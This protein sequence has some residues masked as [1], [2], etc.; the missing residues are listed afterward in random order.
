MIKLG[1][2]GWG[3][4]GR[5]YIK[6]LDTTVDAELSWVCELRPEM[7]SDVKKRY[8]HVH[9]TASVD[10]LIKQKLDGIIIATPATTHFALAKKIIPT[11]TAL[12][13]EKP[14][15]SSLVQ[16]V[17]LKQLVKKYKACVLVGHTF[18]YNQAVRWLKAK[19]DKR[20]FGKLFHI[21]CKRQS[22]GPIR[23]DVNIIWDFAPHDLSMI[24]YLLG[25]KMPTSIFAKAKRYMRH[26][27]EDIASIMLE[28]GSSMLVTINVAWLYPM[29][30]RML[31][32]LGR[33]R[34]AVFEDTN[35]IEPVKIYNTIIRYPSE[36]DPYKAA[37]RLGNVFIP[38][39]E[40]IDPLATEIKHFVA[41]INKEQEPITSVSD[42]FTNVLLLEAISQSLREKKEVDFRKFASSYV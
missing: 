12:L 30:I 38:R 8:P 31:T 4:W 39:I 19:V 6:Y 18:L 3:Y 28:Y 35:Q 37:F 25:N 36:T 13:I 27:Q 2:I 34:M 33:K 16:A 9:T 20:Y 1:I 41:C 23:D 5:N 40:P 10:E 22:Y 14:L 15:T 26:P 32:L 11:G 42:G 17:E 21:E 24:T 7:L 29:K